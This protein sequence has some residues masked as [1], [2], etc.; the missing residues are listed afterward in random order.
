MIVYLVGMVL[1]ISSRKKLSPLLLIK[2]AFPTFLIALTTA[3][4]AAAF[5]TNVK[6]ANKKLGID[7]NLV[8]LTNITIAQ[9]KRQVLDDC[10]FNMN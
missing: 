7:K 9:I 8:G 3:S 4:S 10:K 2:K 5:S 6:D 1:W